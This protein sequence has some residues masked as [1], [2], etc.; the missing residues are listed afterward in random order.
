[1][2]K[3]VRR[4]GEFGRYRD[5]GAGLA[6]RGTDDSRGFQPTDTMPKRNCVAS[7]RLN[8]TQH[9]RIQA[10]LRDAWPFYVIIRGFKPTATVRTSLRD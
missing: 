7:R 6:E 1:M 3:S 9:Q 8:A 2:G 10:S 5:S 4:F